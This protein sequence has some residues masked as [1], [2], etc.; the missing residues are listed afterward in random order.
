MV[1]QATMVDHGPAPGSR[2]MLGGVRGASWQPNSELAA[3][4]IE[5][6]NTDCQQQWPQRDMQHTE[7]QKQAPSNYLDN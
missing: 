3:K 7:S 6:F 1:S 5:I 2:V 4:L